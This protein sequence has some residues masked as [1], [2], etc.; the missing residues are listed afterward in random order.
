MTSK[1]VLQMWDDPE[2]AWG[3]HKELEQFWAD[4][5]SGLVIV[6]YTNGTRTYVTLPERST[7]KYSKVFQDFEHDSN[8][9]AVLSTAPSQDSYEYYLYPKAKNKSV[10]YVITH[11]KKYFNPI[12][13]GS[14]VRVP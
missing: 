2:T 13:P 7:K 9:V 8:I 5:A 6:V 4:L 3:K 1:R 14:K 12:L 10:E 11:Y